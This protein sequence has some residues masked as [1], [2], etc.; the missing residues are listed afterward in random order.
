M[1]VNHGLGDSLRKIFIYRKRLFEGIYQDVRQKYVG[2]LFGMTWAVLLPLLQLGIYA[3]LY[4]FIFKVRPSGLNEF[5]YVMLVCSGLVPLMAFNEIVIGAMNSL[6]ANKSLLMNTVFPAEFIPLRAGIAGHATSLIG[7]A[8]T[9]VAGYA[10]GCAS[11]QAIILVPVFWIFLAMFAMGIGWL[12]SLA[13]LVVRDIQYSMGIILMLAMLLSPFAYTADMVPRLLK[14]LIYMN[15]LSYFVLCFQS[16]ICYGTW[17][18]WHIACIAAFLG[19]FSFL[20]GLQIFQRVKYVF[21]DY[22]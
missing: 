13:T 1:I 22:A 19:T 2:S 17:P 3:G 11:W 21:F 14:P 16:L 5:G 18:P 10:T 20:A 4:Y 6:A 12:L 15:P 9:L 7:L 8:I